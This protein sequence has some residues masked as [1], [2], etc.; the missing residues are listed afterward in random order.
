MEQ[1]GIEIKVGIVIFICMVMLVGLLIAVGGKGLFKKTYDVKVRFAFTDGLEE[2]APVRFA[3][4]EVGKVTGI[5]VIPETESKREDGR[6][7]VTLRL[8][9]GLIL[10]KDCKIRLATLGLMGERYISLSP[11]RGVA[12][13][14]EQGDVL[15]GEDPLEMSQVIAQG[16][17]VLG[18]LKDITDSLSD[19]LEAILTRLENLLN[20]ADTILA[21]NQEDIRESIKNLK[22]TTLHAKEFA[23]KINEKPNAIIWGYKE[24]GDTYKERRER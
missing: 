9:K 8:D 11:G 22:E 21:Q 12:E 6:I 19:N 4:V 24:K 7:E 5:M 18:N 17:E 14:V 1:K 15:R 23:R 3:G 16:K 20:N 2:N 13:I 10:H